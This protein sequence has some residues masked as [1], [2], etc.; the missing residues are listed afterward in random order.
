MVHVVVRLL[1]VVA[2]ALALDPEALVESLLEKLNGTSVG[3]A[4][5]GCLGDLGSV[6]AN[7]N[8]SVA[9]FE[10]GSATSGLDGLY[11]S[12]RALAR[13]VDGCDGP[14][15]L[16]YLEKGANAIGFNATAA[17]AGEALSVVVLGLNVT[18]DVALIAADLAAGDAQGAGAALGSLLVALDGAFSCDAASNDGSCFLFKASLVSPKVDPV[19][20]PLLRGPRRRLGQHVRRPRPPRDALLLC[21]RRRGDAPPRHGPL[22][23]AAV[24]PRDRR[25]DENRPPLRRALAAELPGLR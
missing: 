21:A 9:A 18:E 15:A 1:A 8:A 10:A 13:A 22:E 23:R 3:P 4:I 7:L 12:T 2:G 6:A 24:C 16:G 25:K 19:A 5:E 17:Y 11:L 20:L 14:V